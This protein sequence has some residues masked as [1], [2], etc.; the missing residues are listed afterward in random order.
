MHAGEHTVHVDGKHHEEVASVA[1]SS[2]P[3]ASFFNKPRLQQS[4]IEADQSKVGSVHCKEQLLF[5][6]K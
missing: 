6:A 3:I 2:R 5:Y 4:V 1:S